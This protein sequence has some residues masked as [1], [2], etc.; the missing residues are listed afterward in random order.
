[1][2]KTYCTYL[3]YL[4]PQRL[5]SAFM[6]WL[7]E[8]RLPWLKNAMIT[9][10][11]RRY[12]QINLSEAIIENPADF[13][14]FN[15]FFIRELK[16]SAR[17]ITAEKNVIASPVDGSV[18]QCGGIQR[19][20]LLQAKNHSFRLIDLLGGDQT[21]T[22]LFQDG[23]FATLYLAPFNYHRVHMPLA[24]NLKK[25]MYVPGNLF[26]VNR[27]T[28]ELIP[29]IY[30][31]NERIVTLFETDAGPMAVI[32]VGALIV[33]SMQL[34][35]EKNPTR[36]AHLMTQ[37]FS[38]QSSK[39]IELAKGAELGYFKMGSTVIVLFAKDRARWIESLQAGAVVRLGE[40]MGKY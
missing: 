32:L 35:W 38:E 4:L 3:Q 6:G 25:M 31:R 5:I 34:A 9:L 21:L 8:S 1:M 23:E 27:M 19:G 7:A 28:A 37:D 30:A 20:Q 10:F 2:L 40:K 14:T 39:S 26:S 17:P 24:G 13:P 36:A 33:G 11:M 18:A 22:T 29:H 16:P 15:Q 12:P